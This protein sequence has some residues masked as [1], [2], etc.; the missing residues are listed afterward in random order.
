MTQS[1]RGGVVSVDIPTLENYWTK[2]V[3]LA[4]GARPIDLNHKWAPDAGGFITLAPIPPQFGTAELANGI[5][6]HL[7]TADVG[8]DSSGRPIPPTARLFAHP[9]GPAASHRTGWQQLPIA[10]IE[11]GLDGAALAAQRYGDTLVSAV[12]GTVTGQ[13]NPFWQLTISA[14]TSSSQ[15]AD[16]TVVQSDDPNNVSRPPITDTDLLVWDLFVSDGDKPFVWASAGYRDAGFNQDGFVNITGFPLDADAASIGTNQLQFITVTGQPPVVEFHR[17]GLTG[18][19]RHRVPWGEQRFTLPAF[20]KPWSTDAATPAPELWFLVPQLNGGNFT[21]CFEL[22]R[23]RWLAGQRRRIDVAS[24]VTG[25]RDVEVLDDDANFSDGNTRYPRHNPHGYAFEANWQ[26]ANHRVG[27]VG[28]LPGLDLSGYNP[29]LSY[30]DQWQ[31]KIERDRHRPGV[32]HF[33]FA[34]SGP[35]SYD[36]YAKIGAVWFAESLD[37]GVHW[38]QPVQGTTGA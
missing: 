34:T 26:D 6:G 30:A 17:T 31:F 24:P 25:A 7:Q 28:P 4:D 3:H 1:V 11:G 13:G 21:G 20:V 27:V 37:D 35:T 19:Y 33:V 9:P 32:L 14:W 23:S 8:V 5:A 15:H 29:D 2:T 36:P 38:S 12:I 16:L 10:I 22:Y 18:G